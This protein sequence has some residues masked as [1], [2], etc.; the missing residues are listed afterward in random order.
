MQNTI[1]SYN[2]STVNTSEIGTILEDFTYGTSAKMTIPSLVPFIDP[3]SITTQKRSINKSNIQNK[4]IDSLHFDTTEVCNYIEVLIPEELYRYKNTNNEIP[5]Y[6]GNKGEQ[7]LISFIGG[8]IN[9]PI[10]VR[11]L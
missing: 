11:R 3:T 5:S 2:N 1:T 9:K 8:D 7:F 6:K 10:A 4:D